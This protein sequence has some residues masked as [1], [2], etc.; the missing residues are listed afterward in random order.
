MIRAR[1]FQPN[2]FLREV[3]EGVGGAPP[4]RHFAEKC[5]SFGGMPDSIDGPKASK[6]I[7]GHRAL[8]ERNEED[9]RGRGTGERGEEG[10]H[11][12]GWRR[13]KN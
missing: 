7:S 2:P 4:V 8:K 13:A 10:G 3:K 12:G 9:P 11:G 5:V 1:N 6:G